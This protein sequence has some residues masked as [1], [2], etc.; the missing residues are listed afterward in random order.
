M[1]E[2]SKLNFNADSGDFNCGV[3]YHLNQ[4]EDSRVQAREIIFLNH[5]DNDVI[6]S[7]DSDDVDS[8]S[9]AVVSVREEKGY[10]GFP[11]P[12]MPSDNI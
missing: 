10:P 8:I 3:L 11:I 1:A 5:S 2:A 9:D 4:P 6:S 7:I 12:E